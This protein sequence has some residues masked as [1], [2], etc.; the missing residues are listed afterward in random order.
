M[1][2][3]PDCIRNNTPVDDVLH[4]FSERIHLIRLNCLLLKFVL[5]YIIISVNLL[6]FLLFVC[7]REYAN[8]MAKNRKN[9][10]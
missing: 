3:K 9:E 5:N 10:I 6:M 7:N 2:R 8:P 1:N 4:L